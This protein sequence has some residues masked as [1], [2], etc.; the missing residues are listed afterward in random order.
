MSYLLVDGQN[1]AHIVHG[2]HMYRGG[3]AAE[4]LRAPNGQYTTMLKGTLNMIGGMLTQ[5]GPQNV[6]VAYDGRQP[7]WRYDLEPKYKGGLKPRS[8]RSPFG[9]QIEEMSEH[10]KAFGIQTLRTSTLEADDIVALLAEHEELKDKKKVLVSD[11]RDI[12][13]YVGSESY[14]YSPKIKKLVAPSN[15]DEYTK[16]VF[17]I[18]SSV[19]TS[20]WPLFRALAGDT[21]DNIKGVNL[22]GPAYAAEIVQFLQAEGAKLTGY[23]QS[24]EDILPQV[25]ALLPKM[26]KKHQNLLTE[27]GLEELEDC[28]N[29]V[30]VA[31]AP[32]S[33]REIIRTATIEVPATSVTNIQNTLK[34]LGFKQWEN[35][36]K[37]MQKFVTEKDLDLGI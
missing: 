20:G 15:F 32:A 34:L 10:L 3:E 27:K 18:K 28:Y 26:P 29:L 4:E 17:K 12:L 1:I 11:D 14:F 19:G 16:N 31:N 6:I 33:E 30:R 35:D 21:G 5:F 24:A 7:S 9:I 2:I 23:K 37:W 25:R 36:H 22:C 13:A 8:G